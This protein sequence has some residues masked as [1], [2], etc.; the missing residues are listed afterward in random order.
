MFVHMLIDRSFYKV[1]YEKIIQKNSNEIPPIQ[2]CSS[3]LN[4]ELVY[5][6]LKGVTMFS[7]VTFKVDNDVVENEA[8]FRVTT[9]EIKPKL[10]G[11]D[12]SVSFNKLKIKKKD[13]SQSCQSEMK[14]ESW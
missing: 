11:N 13:W 1:I 12:A 5:S 14:D 10:S 8:F 7:Q 2:L 9:G 6:I 4:A 3:Q